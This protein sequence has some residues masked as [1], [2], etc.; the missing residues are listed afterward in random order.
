[1][2]KQFNQVQ[3][4][5]LR[6]RISGLE[7][8]PVGFA[9][10]G[11]GPEAAGFWTFGVPAVDAALPAGGLLRQG[12][13]Q[14][15]AAE[16]ADWPAATGFCLG[17]LRRLEAGGMV[18]WCQTTRLAR[19]YGRPYGH[20]LLQ[21]FGLDPRRLI[22]VTAGKDKDVLWAMEEGLRCR[23]LAGV[24]GEL[25][26]AD[27]TATRRLSLACAEGGTAGLVLSR[28]ETVEGSGHSQWRVSAL[29]MDDPEP[30]SSRFCVELVRCRGGRPGHWKLEWNNATG[31]FDLAAPVAAGA[32]APAAVPAGAYGR[33]C[34]S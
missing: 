26:Q 14:V 6:Q 19:E 25:G 32:A 15:T 31:G 2:N 10:A 20:G 4:A 17:L 13:H 8:R 22:F 9:A 12:L 30:G 7:K 18:L 24:V 16:S 11:Q 27:F 34:A 3:L 29:A 23:A 1:M 28:P 33:K 5:D 21:G